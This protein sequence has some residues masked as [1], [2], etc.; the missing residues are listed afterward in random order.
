MKR[1]LVRTAAATA[2]ALAV[3]AP[4]AEAACPSRTFSQH[5][6]PFADMGWY[7]LAPNGD[8]ETGSTGWALTG[9]ARIVEANPALIGDQLGDRHALELP[10]GATATSPPVC[11][12]SGYPSARAFGWTRLRSLTSG[13]T[14]K[15]EIVHADAAGRISVSP[16]GSAPDLF[17][18]S[19]MRKLSLTQGLS[20]S[21]S[22][23][24][25][26]WIR[27]R[28]TA[29]PGSHWWIDGLYVDP[30]MRR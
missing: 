14:L 7:T 30:M 28:F 13:S 5:F 6:L 26:A 10:A 8:M 18:W 29:A 2:L 20:L 11:I 16:V 12:Q 25:S 9:G 24:G 1:L 22:A 19:P 15:V 3:L 21:K 17:V 27:Y 4:A 23:D